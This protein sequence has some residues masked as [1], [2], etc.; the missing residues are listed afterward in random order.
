MKLALEKTNR[1]LYET[2]TNLGSVLKVYQEPLQEDLPLK[3]TWRWLAD[4][5]GSTEYYE[6]SLTVFHTEQEAVEN[7]SR[8]LTGIYRSRVIITLA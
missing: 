2:V 4:L 6:D 1:T 3:M 8:V 5:K 7:L